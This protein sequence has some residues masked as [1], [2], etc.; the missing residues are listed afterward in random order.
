MTHLAPSADVSGCGSVRTMPERPD[1][2]PAH[3]ARGRR[4]ALHRIGCPASAA[5]RDR[6]AAAPDPRGSRPAG[7]PGRPP[8]D[9]P[10]VVHGD[11]R[12]DR[13]ALRGATRAAD[14]L[15]GVSR[16]HRRVRV[17]AGRGAELPAH[18]AGHARARDRRRDRRGHPVDDR[19]AADA[20][21]AGARYG[22]LRRRHRGRLD[23][24]RRRRR[25]PGGGR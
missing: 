9:D 17:A 7:E 8:D 21:A 13:P 3:P 25:A 24:R 20:G 14:G 15:R 2:G 10:G 12:P 19:I 4:R 6:A 1:A 5:A 11:L 16:A 22:S 23:D 18:P